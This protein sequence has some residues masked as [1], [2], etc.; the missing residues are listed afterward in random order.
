MEIL[1]VL[2]AI[3]IGLVIG[4]LFGKSKIGALSV[5]NELLQNDV[6]AAQKSLEELEAKVEAANSLLASAVAERDKAILERDA[7]SDKC[8]EQK[9]NY[10]RLLSEKEKAHADSVAEQEKRHHEALDAMQK[11]FDET[12]AKVEAQMK[13]ATDSML[14]ERQKEFAETSTNNIGQI[15]VPL[16]ETIEKMKKAMDDSTLR[17]ASMSSAMKENIEH[18]MRQSEAARKSAE[19]LARVF[20]HGS[21]VQGDWGETVLDELLQSQGLTK[22]IHYD[23]QATIKDAS[24]SVVKSAE[25]SMLRPDVILHLD[26]RREVIIDSKVS[27]TAFID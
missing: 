13:S 3:A 22:G 11:R 4:W 26:Q 7:L 27:L 21:K 14:K 1:Y 10:E 16:R 25:G 15:V 9:L 20:K 6:L 8:S 23:T 18:M 19:E 2:I 17:Q 5:R 12:I 24:G